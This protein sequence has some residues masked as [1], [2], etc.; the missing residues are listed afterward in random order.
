MLDELVTEQIE[1]AE[2]D[3]RSSSESP[4]PDEEDPKREEDDDFWG[5]C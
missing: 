1:L 3:Q 4:L 2:A 5:S